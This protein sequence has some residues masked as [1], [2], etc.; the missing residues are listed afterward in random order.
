MGVLKTP[1]SAF[2][3]LQNHTGPSLTEAL[4]PQR[5]AQNALVDELGR[6]GSSR[7]HYRRVGGKSLELISGTGPSEGWISTQIAG[8]TL[9]VKLEEAPGA[10][11][12]GSWSTEGTGSMPPELAT[13]LEKGT[14]HVTACAC[15]Q[16]DLQMFHAIRQELSQGQRPFSGNWRPANDG[17]WKTPWRNGLGSEQVEAADGQ[18]LPYLAKTLRKLMDMVNAEMLQW[19]ANFYEDGSVGCEFH[20]DGHAEHNITVG[21]SFGAARLLTF[22]HEDTGAER[23]FLQRNGDIF[24][25][26]HSVDEKFMHGVYPVEDEALGPRISVIIMGRL[27]PNSGLHRSFVQDQRENRQNFFHDCIERFRRLEKS[28]ETQEAT[29]LEKE[30]YHSGWCSRVSRRPPCGSS[31]KKPRCRHWKKMLENCWKE[32]IPA[33]R[34]CNS[35]WKS[36]T[37]T[38]PGEPNEGMK[39]GTSHCLVCLGGI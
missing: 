4:L 23:S 13:I 33:N 20:H 22:H 19:W 28:I 16:E 25:F 35:C 34:A 30:S 37:G 10:A 15:D 14:K 9:A 12:D 5:L 2:L 27:R 21:A 6:A 32:S 31:W 17:K 7:L 1:G 38:H 8:K 39:G 18:K 24:A 36:S 29:L 11:A 26:D 3:L